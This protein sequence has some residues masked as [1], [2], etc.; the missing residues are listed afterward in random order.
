MILKKYLKTASIFGAAVICAASCVY[1]DENL[2]RNFIPSNQIYETGRF[3]VPLQEIRMGYSDSLSAYSSSRITV[4]AVVDDKFGLSTRSSAFS[5]IPLAESMDLGT[6]PEIL[7][8]HFTAVRDTLSCPDMSQMGIIQNINVYALPQMLDST[9]LY[10]VDLKDEDFKDAVRISKGVPTYMGGDSLSFDFTMEYAQKIVDACRENKNLPGDL[11]AFQ[12]KIPGIYLCADKP[13]GKGG[14]INMFDATLEISDSYY[15]TGNYAELKIRTKY[16]GSDEP[17]DTSFLFVFGAT[18]IDSNMEQYAFNICGH[19]SNPRTDGNIVID[20]TS[21]EIKDGYIAA[22]DKIYIEGGG[23]LKPVIDAREIRSRI[24]AELAAQGISADKYKRVIINKAT[25]NLPFEEPETYD[26]K[27][28][29]PQILSPTC[30]F[31]SSTGSKNHK[32]EALRHVT[33]AGLTDASV[34]TENQ[35]DVN[36]S[37]MNY[38]PDISHHVQEIM[39]APQ[40]SLNKGNYDIWLLIMANE[41]IESDTDEEQDEMNQYYQNL[42]YANYYNSLYGGGYGYGGYGYG[43]YGYGYGGYGDYYSNYYNYMMMAQYASGSSSSKT[44]TSTQLDKDRYYSAALE[45][46]YNADGTPKVESDKGKPMLTVVYS[47]V[48]E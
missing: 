10:T 43:G 2:G 40:E 6:E 31:S 12:K 26:G 23:G 24:E 19:S 41:V 30:K 28:L 3:E 1:I 33:Y 22:K 17:K 35:G 7:Q 20:G 9:F 34:S 13:Y 8:F 29:I 27:S 14:R 21:L 42:A 48:K 15:I 36:Y 47:Y 4:G 25:V 18:S 38:S 44:E 46:A 39:R 45:G 37:L 5:L 16:S 11:T 32:G